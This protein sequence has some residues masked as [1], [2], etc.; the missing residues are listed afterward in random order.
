ML[1]C[2]RLDH[3]SLQGG[4]VE[5]DQACL[6]YARTSDS[7]TWQ[8]REA[9]R[10]APGLRARRG[11]AIGSSLQT[12]RDNGCDARAAL[13]PARRAEPASLRPVGEGESGVGG[14]IQEGLFQFEDDAA[15]VVD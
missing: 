8:A 7:R 9:C 5:H 10:C 6:A 11:R 2:V 12:R 1:E 15:V 3:E 14:A 13:A 4:N